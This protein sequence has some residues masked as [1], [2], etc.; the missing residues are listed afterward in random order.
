MATHPTPRPVLA[1]YFFAIAGKQLNQVV[2]PNLGRSPAT[3]VALPMHNHDNPQ[4]AAAWE[5][6]MLRLANANLG[7]LRQTH[8][9]L[10]GLIDKGTRETAKAWRGWSGH[11][12]G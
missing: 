5:A 8:R 7:L 4:V 2:P 6:L 11:G 3:Q 12:R 9:D 1:A 10:S